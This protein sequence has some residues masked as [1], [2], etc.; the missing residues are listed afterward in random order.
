MLR[1]SVPVSLF[2]V[3]RTTS[4]LGRIDGSLPPLP[5]TC[6]VASASRR[7]LAVLPLGSAFPGFFPALR[8]EWNAH[9]LPRVFEVHREVATGFEADH[10][11]M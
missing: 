9:T 6:L 1:I 7:V 4:D 8:A 5:A 3:A 11:D 2:E 10:P